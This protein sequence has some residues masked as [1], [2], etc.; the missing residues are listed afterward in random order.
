[1]RGLRGLHFASAAFSSAGHLLD[2]VPPS[3]PAPPP[4]TPAG[5]TYHDAIAET[6]V[7][8]KAIG[9]LPASMQEERMVRAPR[10]ARRRAAPGPRCRAALAH[11]AARAPFPP[12]AFF[13]RSA[14]S[15]AP[16]TSR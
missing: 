15:S 6:G 5:L 10:R 11:P 7:Y 8:E 16:R 14:A 12:L 2:P 4:R 13:R 1:V 9:R 3:R